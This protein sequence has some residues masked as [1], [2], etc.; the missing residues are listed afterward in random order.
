M[1]QL[2]PYFVLSMCFA[3]AFLFAFLIDMVYVR[4]SGLASVLENFCR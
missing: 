2:R 4:G 1:I 3:V